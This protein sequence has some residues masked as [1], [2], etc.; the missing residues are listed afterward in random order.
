[1]PNYRLYRLDGVGKIV[2]ADWLEAEDDRQAL[3]DAEERAGGSRYE[4]WDRKRLV[5][6]P[7]RI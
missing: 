6:T 5:S 3:E 4:L 2:G 7:H 1:L